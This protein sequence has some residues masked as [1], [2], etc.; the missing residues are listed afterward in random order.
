MTKARELVE[1][2]KGIKRE[3]KESSYWQKQVKAFIVSAITVLKQE[4]SDQN[5]L[6][7]IAKLEALSDQ[8]EDM[9][10]KAVDKKKEIEDNGKDRGDSE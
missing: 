4:E 1:K 8:L 6:T 3:F 7:M 2:L 10:Q 9:Y 5:A